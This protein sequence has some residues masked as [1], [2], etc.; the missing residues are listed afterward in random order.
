[1]APD[2]IVTVFMPTDGEPQPLIAKAAAVLLK[3]DR[4]EGAWES[5][6]PSEREVTARRCA[7]KYCGVRGRTG[8]QC[9]RSRRAFLADDGEDCWLKYSVTAQ[10]QFIRKQIWN[11]GNQESQH[12]S[13]PEF[14]ISK[15]IT[16]PLRNWP[17]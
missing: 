1:M 12:G 5:V 9:A 11:S 7:P 6:F 3:A 14:L 2:S 13:L 4:A 15:L 17:W 8:R 10:G 16:L